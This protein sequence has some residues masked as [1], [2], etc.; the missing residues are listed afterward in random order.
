MMLGSAHPHGS[1]QVANSPKLGAISPEFELYGHKGIYVMDASF[2][3]T[4]L[5][6]NPQITTMSSVLRAS[7]NLV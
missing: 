6:V 5:S 3:P 7:R 2:Y 4:G 1:I